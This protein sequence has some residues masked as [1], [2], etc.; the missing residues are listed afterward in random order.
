MGVALHARGDV[1]GRLPVNIALDD[2]GKHHTAGTREK[3]ALR[4]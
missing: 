1:G 2:L 4:W 3:E